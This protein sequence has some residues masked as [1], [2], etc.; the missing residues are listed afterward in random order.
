MCRLDQPLPYLLNYRVG[1]MG[2]GNDNA[3]PGSGLSSVRSRTSKSLNTTEHHGSNDDQDF[4]DQIPKRTFFLP[5]L[6]M[7]LDVFA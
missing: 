1:W 5:K 6:N 7:V 4:Q 3:A 2:V